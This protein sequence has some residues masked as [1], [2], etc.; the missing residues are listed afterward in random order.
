MQ[1][2]PP[3]VILIF[4]LK[5]EKSFNKLH[6]FIFKLK[7]LWFRLELFR[8]IKRTKINSILSRVFLTYKLLIYLLQKHSMLSASSR[9]ARTPLSPLTQST[10]EKHLPGLTPKRFLQQNKPSTAD[11]GCITGMLYKL[12]RK[13][14][15]SS[16]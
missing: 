15:F 12:F 16:I 11:V 7:F 4:F 3:Y 8:D 2:L 14:Q 9:G 1:S 10:L 13:A 6:C 5:I